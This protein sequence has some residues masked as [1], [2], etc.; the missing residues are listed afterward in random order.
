MHSTSSIAT[1]PL[2]SF[3]TIFETHNTIALAGESSDSRIRFGADLKNKFHNIISPLSDYDTFPLCRF[4][5][6]SDISV[7]T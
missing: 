4:L 5:Y 1:R 3:L 2:R 7:E 6:R